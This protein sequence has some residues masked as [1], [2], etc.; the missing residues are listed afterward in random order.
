MNQTINIA[1]TPTN[2][3]YQLAIV[4][5]F[6]LLS[7]NK[8]NAVNFYV[9]VDE[10][11]NDKYKDEFKS[12]K[13]FKNCN[14]IN[15]I[16]ATIKYS[17]LARNKIVLSERMRIYE[18]GNLIQEDKILFIDAQTIVNADLLELY[19]TPIDGYSCA[20]AEYIPVSYTHLTLPT[21]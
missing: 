4:S 19:N 2:N 18:L 8:N 15:F 5:M 11:F 12:L 1:Y 20:A 14:S 13:Q 16:T 6:S 3:S 10:S 7:N 17:D 21:T 9:I